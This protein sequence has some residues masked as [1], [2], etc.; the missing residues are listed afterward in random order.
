MIFHDSEKGGH[1]HIF[2]LIF[3]IYVTFLSILHSFYFEYDGVFAF[4]DRW[5]AR[6]GA[7]I[8]IL[9]MI[10]KK[11]QIGKIEIIS[12]ILIIL[13]YI[14]T[15]SPIFNYKFTECFHL[16]FRYFVYIFLIVFFH[17]LFNLKSSLHEHLKVFSII[18]VIYIFILFMIFSH[19]GYY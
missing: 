2:W 11:Y 13:F 15:M 9:C 19:L 16:I 1:A 14:L 7:I 4:L 5:F 3:L 12:L 8:F 17:K 18:H 6:I 10:F